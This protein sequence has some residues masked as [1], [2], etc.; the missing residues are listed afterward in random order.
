MTISHSEF[1]LL[2]WVILT[3]SLIQPLEAHMVQQDNFCGLKIYNIY[4]NDIPRFSDVNL[5]LFADDTAI[6][7]RTHSHTLCFRN[8]KT[9]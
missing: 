1:S 4:T 3:L 2:G 6:M 5:A 9:I 7:Y 8:S